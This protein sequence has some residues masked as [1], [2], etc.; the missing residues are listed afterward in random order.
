MSEKRLISSI[1]DQKS[2]LSTGFHNIPKV[3]FLEGVNLTA[4]IPLFGL[5]HCLQVAGISIPTGSLLVEGLLTP[6]E[7]TGVFPITG[8]V[9]MLIK[10]GGA[11]WSIAKAALSCVESFELKSLLECGRICDR[12]CVSKL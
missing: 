5:L 1:S 10:V 6:V 3:H 7:L 9:A 11:G 2:S 8:S 12:H 4:G